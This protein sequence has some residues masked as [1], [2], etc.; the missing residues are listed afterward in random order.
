MVARHRTYAIGDT[1]SNSSHR[2][3]AIVQTLLYRKTVVV[4]NSSYKRHRINVIGHNHWPKAI[5]KNP[6]DEHHWTHAIGSTPLNARSW[7]HAI[8]HTLLDARHRTYA[9]GDTTSMKRH[10]TQAIAQEPSYK[11]YRQE[12][13]SSYLSRLTSTIRQTSLDKSPRRRPLKQS[14]ETNTVG[15]T[16]LDPRH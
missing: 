10:Q 5:G 3:R 9:I 4:L 1:P 6:F 14:P 12:K 7:T 16:P 13:Q 2:S 11:R 15:L 8:G